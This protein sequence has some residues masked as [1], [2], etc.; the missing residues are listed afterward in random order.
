[1]K[2]AI[3]DRVKEFR[4]G[5]RSRPEG[6]SRSDA[7]KV[8]QQRAD[9]VTPTGPEAPLKA[10]RRVGPQRAGHFGLRAQV[11]KTAARSVLP[12]Q[13]TQGTPY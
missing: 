9:R 11:E 7:N 13:R 6:D 12:P 3:R 1:M 2:A 8:R 4:R 10:R 5:T